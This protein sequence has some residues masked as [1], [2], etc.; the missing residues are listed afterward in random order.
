MVFEKVSAIL[1]SQLDVE[2]SSITMES[3]LED[4]HADSLALVDV[5]LTLEDEF[6]VEFPEDQIEN[7]KTVGDIVDYIEKNK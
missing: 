7:M 2:E 5:V 3:T 4:L 6:S 1:A